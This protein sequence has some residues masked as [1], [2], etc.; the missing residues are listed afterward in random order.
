MP[1]LAKRWRRTALAGLLLGVLLCVTGVG[2]YG[3]RKLSAPVPP[4]LPAVGFDTGLAEALAAA[5]L[6]VQQSPYDA[7][8]WGELG[9]L[10]RDAGLAPEGSICFAQ[11]EHLDPTEP[12][13]PY[14]QGEQLL[15]QDPELARPLLQ[16]AAELC[17]RQNSDTIAPRLRLAELLMARGEYDEAALQLRRAQEKERDNPTIF[18]NLGLLA[19]ARDD[20]VASRSLLLRCQFS[21]YT[22]RRACVQLAALCQRQGEAQAAMEF[23]ARARTL[24]KDQPWPDPLRALSSRTL[25]TKASRL[26]QVNRL[27]AQQRPSEAVAILR[28]MEAEGPDYRVSVALGRNLAE[29]GQLA[30]AEQVLQ[31][32]I[33]LAPDNVLAYYYRSKVRWGLAESFARPG[34]DKDRAVEFYRAAAADAREA[35][36][37]KPDHAL[38]YMVLGQCLKRLNQRADATAALRKAVQC[39]P[40]LVDPALY[41]GEILAEDGQN[42]EA[43]IV[44]EQAV[45]LAKA[46]DARPRVALAKLQTG[47]P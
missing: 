11:A 9:V 34:G 14:L 23:G 26:D 16:R 1:A 30:E 18:L 42:A 38:A 46:E 13:W 17:D 10:F 19:Y 8:A 31:E 6:K 40:D 20:L 33:K 22:Q 2:W 32:A 24:P 36:A 43:R 5:R 37:R 45:R 44:L 7:P 41:L 29:L 4:E 21:P 35:V 3:W 25:E 28:E 27:Q 39:G 47:K 15:V 12:R